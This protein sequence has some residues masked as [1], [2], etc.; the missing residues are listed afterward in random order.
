MK[1]IKTY[2][3]LDGSDRFL[4]I[5]K[6]GNLDELKELLKRSD[7]DVN[8]QNK[9]GYTALNMASA[10]G[11]LDKVKELL[12]QGI[13][14]NIQDSDGWTALIWA[15][16]K[17]HLDIVKELLKRDKIDVN[18]KTKNGYT[19]LICASYCGYIKI[20]KELLNQGI[21]V[22][23]QNNY[24]WTALIYASYKGHLDIVKELLKKDEINLN[25]KDN[26]GKDF[27]DHLKDNQKEII[28]IEFPEEYEKYLMNK[29]INKY[30]I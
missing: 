12:N 2:E 24:G 20:V 22:N 8:I 21:D 17:G 7:I 28:M 16:F 13:D 6:D 15:S 25:L 4:R 10:N 14:V 26:D 5:A 9:D 3:Q 18:I 23:I 27:F 11:R 1:Y 29:K 30:N 19:A